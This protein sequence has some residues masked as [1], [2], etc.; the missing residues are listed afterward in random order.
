MTDTTLLRSTRRRNLK[1]SE[2]IARDIANY[3][4]D[5]DLP[6]GARLPRE[7]EMLEMMGVGRMTLREA[8]RLLET[9]GVIDIRSGAQGGPVVR[10]PQPEDLA[11]NLT[12][13]LQFHG[14]SLSDVMLARQALEPLIAR[15]AATHATDEQLDELAGTIEKMRRHAG[16]EDVFLR[17]NERFHQL[18]A[19]ASGSVSLRVFSAT[20]KNIASGEDAGVEYRP[21]QHVAVA[22]AHG[23][24]LTALR[25]RRPAA[26]EKAMQEHLEE[27]ATY[28]QRRYPELWARPV[29]WIQS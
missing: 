16:R 3:I 13:V 22:R 8:L 6:E 9:Q 12:L 24:I 2:R 26:A 18:V 7:K 27:A 14:A 15:L 4:V 20:L 21:E 5:A 11:G 10:R 29:R 23:R 17:E 1:T 25:N 19:E 28:W